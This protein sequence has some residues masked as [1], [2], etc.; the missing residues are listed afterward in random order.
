M[1]T[2]DTTDQT[3]KGI[4]LMREAYQKIPSTGPI[5]AVRAGEQPKD[6]MSI[7]EETLMELL[8]NESNSKE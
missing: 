6:T 5:R 1:D 8:K 4:E 7:F 2:K 3:S